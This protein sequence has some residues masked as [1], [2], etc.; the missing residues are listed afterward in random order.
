MD[1]H[2]LHD[3]EYRVAIEL[4]MIDREVPEPNRSYAIA[5]KDYLDLNDRKPKTIARRLGE[6]RFV[7]KALNMDAKK[8]TLKDIEEVVRKIN[9]GKRRDGKGK[10]TKTELAGI[11]KRKLK[12][13]V[14]S[15]YK[16]LVG[17]GQES[18]TYFIKDENESGLHK[19]MMEEIVNILNIKEIKILKIAQS[20]SRSI[21]DIE[22]S[23]FDIEV[24]TVLKHAKADLKERIMRSKKHVIIVVP[25]TQFVKQYKEMR[26][27]NVD[28]I[29]LADFE[30]YID[31]KP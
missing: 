6:L 24:E 7:L 31:K 16:W 17:N 18:P 5:Y 27:E 15:F 10:D 29:A 2:Y 3:G 12:Q 14:R 9:K 21:S 1:R 30:T 20:G 8:A 22:T 11:T 4:R 28:V 26:S 13:V 19:G 23:K 25:D